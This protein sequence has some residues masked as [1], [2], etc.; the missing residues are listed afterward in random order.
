MG[1]GSSWQCRPIWTFPV[2]D[3]A[4]LAWTKQKDMTFPLKLKSSYGQMSKNV[5]IWTYLSL[6]FPFPL[7]SYLPLHHNES[8]KVQSQGWIKNQDWTELGLNLCVWHDYVSW[9]LYFP[10]SHLVWCSDLPKPKL[11][12]CEPELMVQFR[13]QANPLT[14]TEGLVWGSGKMGSEPNWIKL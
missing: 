1:M 13:V 6:L 11:E 8:L 14:W 7:S 2:L 4:S 3:S 9:F 5:M 10:H 12:H